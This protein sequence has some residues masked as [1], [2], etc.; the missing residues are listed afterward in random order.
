MKIYPAIDIMNGNVVRLK[1]GDP[2]TIIDYSQLGNPLDVALLWESQ[3]AQILHIIDLDS[4]FGNGNN[5]SW[6]SKI[7]NEIS[8]PIQVGG[9]LRTR[10]MITDYLDLGVD[11]VI[12]GSL[13]IHYPEIVLDIGQNYGLGRIVI[14]LDYR[15]SCL[16][17]DGWRREENYDVGDLLSA[18][19]SRGFCNFLMTSVDND[20]HLQGPDLRLVNISK[21]ISDV[22]VAG[23]V[24]SKD[25]IRI[26]ASQGFAGAVVGR[27]LYENRLTL[28]EAI[29]AGRELK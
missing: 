21:T 1:S 28:V 7:I 29:S 13:V 15:N 17:T 18:F 23:G 10:A 20:G 24:S 5:I 3:G 14:S 8:V 9:G 2:S 6:I 22:I 12:L 27:V 26:L 4:A 16:V 25:D 19:R 11:R